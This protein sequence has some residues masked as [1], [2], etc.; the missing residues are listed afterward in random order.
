MT[1]LGALIRLRKFELD[2]RQRELAQLQD[3]AEALVAERQALEARAAAEER[4]AAETPEIGF[5][6]PAFR[7]AV[8]AEYQRIDEAAALLAAMM[9]A[10]RDQIAEGFQ[11]MKKLELTDQARKDRET[12]ELKRKEGELLDDIALEGFRRKQGG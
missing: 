11:E 5:T 4:E 10:K 9:E 2:E 7:Q 8:E 3:R 1:D 12:A 6:M